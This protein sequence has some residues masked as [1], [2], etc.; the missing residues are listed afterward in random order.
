[1]RCAAGRSP[2]PRT[3]RTSARSA[4]NCSASSSQAKGR[5]YLKELRSQAMIEYRQIAMSRPLALTLGEPAGIGPDITLAVWLRRDE[6][7]L[8]P[9]YVHR[10]PEKP[11]APRQA[12]RPRRCRS[13]WSSRSDAAAAFA[14][15]AAGRRLELPAGAEPG[16]P[17]GDQRARRDRLD[18]PRRRRRDRR[19]GCG[20][21]HQSGRQE[22]ALQVGLRRSRAHRISRQ[23]ARS[24]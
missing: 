8:P 22:R 1:M 12:A 3:R 11:A 24:S 2:A 19:H 10:R 17:D 13:R 20:D 7:E 4:T 14:Q 5:A 18:R 15:R 9:F 21:R 6:L 23:A 16:D